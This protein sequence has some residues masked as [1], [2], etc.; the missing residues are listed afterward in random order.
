MKHSREFQ[1]ILSTIL[2][3]EYLQEAR[4]HIQS[5]DFSNEPYADAL[6]R[7]IMLPVSDNAPITRVLVDTESEGTDAQELS[8]RCTNSERPNSI[9]G[10]SGTRKDL[11]RSAGF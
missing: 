6:H 2:M 5:K 7:V 8:I 3:P 4:E 11:R 1:E 10:M 9:R